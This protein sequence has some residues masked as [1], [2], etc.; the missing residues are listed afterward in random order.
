EGNRLIVG[1]PIALIG[2]EPDPDMTLGR[3][4]KKKKTDCPNG[5]GDF[6]EFDGEGVA[7]SE[8]YSYVTGSHGCS[9]SS[10]EFRL[11][12]FLLARIR[13]D[14]QG[15]PAGGEGEPLPAK[16]SARAVEITYRVSDLLRRAGAATGFFGKDLETANGLNI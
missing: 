16:K 9:R 13:V 8:P 3:K 10:G 11:S 5:R 15:R 4:P 6:A 7:Y 2:D 12:S 14:R 1:D